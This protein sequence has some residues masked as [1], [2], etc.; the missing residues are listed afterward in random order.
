MTKTAPRFF[1]LTWVPDPKRY[2][3]KDPYK[4]YQ[5]CL[6]YLR[7]A[8]KVFEEYSFIPELTL[9]GNVHIHGYYLVKDM[10]KFF[11]KFLP[12]LKSCGFIKIKPITTMHDWQAYMMKDMEQNQ[13]LFDGLP[14]PFD[15]DTIIPK[16]VYQSKKTMKKKTYRKTVLD[17]FK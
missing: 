14:Y 15:N 12:M 6:T 8:S 3:T 9:D 2:K 7:M 10:I 1:A 11:R 13:Y 4:Q 16:W 17:Y 5:T